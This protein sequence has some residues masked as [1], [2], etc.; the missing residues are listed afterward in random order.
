MRV[1]GCSCPCAAV[2]VRTTADCG[3]EI[4]LHLEVR[5]VPSGGHVFGDAIDSAIE[6]TPVHEAGLRGVDADSDESLDRLGVGEVEHVARAGRR[7]AGHLQKTTRAV[8][9]EQRRGLQHRSVQFVL[10]KVQDAVV[11]YN[12]IAM[13]HAT[14]VGHVVSAGRAG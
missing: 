9:K 13:I 8:V 14:P 2:H 11:V 3:L 5:G 12:E 7:G 10:R 1:R 4:S 6:I